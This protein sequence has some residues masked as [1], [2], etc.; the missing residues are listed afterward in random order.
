MPPLC[1]LR[2]VITLG[3]S[4]AFIAHRL[5]GSAIKNYSK[6]CAIFG[7]AGKVLQFEAAVGFEPS[8][9]GVGTV[10]SVAIDRRLVRSNG[11]LSNWT[12]KLMSL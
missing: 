7:K 3:K 8:A 11:Y 4:P 6:I 2:D 12:R 9:N 10:C 5:L 1:I